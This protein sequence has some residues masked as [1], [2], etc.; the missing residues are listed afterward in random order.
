MVA[1]T[2]LFTKIRV[3]GGAPAVFPAPAAVDEA[4]G[5]EPHV[6]H[7][8]SQAQ[9]ELLLHYRQMRDGL[10][11]ADDPFRL[12]MPAYGLTPAFLAAGDLLYA[13]A[14]D[15]MA[16]RLAAMAAAL[17]ATEQQ[18]AAERLARTSYAAF[19]RVART[20]IRSAPGR[21]SLKLDENPPLAKEAFVQSAESALAVAQSEP[22]ATLLASA[23]FDAARVAE[24]LSAIQRL[25]VFITA[26][27]VA[28]KSAKHA[29]EARDGA[30]DELRVYVQQMRADVSALL[31]LNPH[32]RAPLG[33]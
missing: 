2:E 22:Y 27:K 33:F 19:R 29:T 5:G 24:T 8:Q 25:A 12:A 32:L 1:E 13:A 23:T 3:N 21:L 10:A 4:P 18:E 9:V 16:A 28:A 30:M 26:R 7:H 11:S 20:I 15:S 6:Q 17:E 31:R 14:A